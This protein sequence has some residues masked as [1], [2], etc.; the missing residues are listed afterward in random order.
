MDGLEEHEHL[1]QSLNRMGKMLLPLPTY[2]CALK[3][4]WAQSRNLEGKLNEKEREKGQQM[5]KNKER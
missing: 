5:K 4:I 3:T 1:R 2:V